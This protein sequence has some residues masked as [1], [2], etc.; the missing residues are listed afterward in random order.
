VWRNIDGMDLPLFT[1]ALLLRRAFLKEE[2][3]RLQN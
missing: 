3:E 2:L 1:E